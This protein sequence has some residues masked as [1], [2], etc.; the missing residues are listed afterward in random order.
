MPIQ[1]TFQS[2]IFPYGVT[3]TLVKRTLAGQDANG[4]DVYTEKNIQV[5]NTVFVPSGASEN[6][7]F[8][9]QTNTTEVFYVPWGTD[10]NALDAII[11]QGDEYEVQGIPSQWVSPFS[12]RPSPIRV[13]AVKVSGVSALWLLSGV[14]ILPI[15]V[16]ELTL[17]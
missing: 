7:I 8:A 1:T 10:V 15:W 17:S 5:P 11:F 3:V 4:N 9:D 12:G 13:N 6:L 16:E 2:P 14:G